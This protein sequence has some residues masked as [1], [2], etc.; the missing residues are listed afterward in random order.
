MILKWA[1]MGHTFA[2]L[3]SL[4]TPPGKIK[5]E[6]YEP[7]RKDTKLEGAGGPPT[8]L[9]LCCRS[10][11]SWGL[12]DFLITPLQMD[13]LKQTLLWNASAKSTC[14]SS[15]EMKCD[16]WWQLAR[17]EVSLVDGYLMLHTIFLKNIFRLGSRWV[18][19]R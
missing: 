6:N 11:K 18:S 1:M 19:K 4:S 15:P 7:W 16:P 5:P 14:P 8:H 3:E 9:D 13:S 12:Y 17:I 10:P 2:W